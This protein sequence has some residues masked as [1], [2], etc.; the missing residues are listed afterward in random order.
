MTRPTIKPPR[1]APTG[2]L[3]P[4]TTAAVKPII[5]TRSSEFGESVEEGAIKSPANE[6]AAPEIAQLSVRA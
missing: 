2:L 5:K 6:D 3:R 1:T 4:P